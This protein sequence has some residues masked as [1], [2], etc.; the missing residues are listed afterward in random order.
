MSH[1][2]VCFVVLGSVFFIAAGEAWAAKLLVAND[3]VDSETCGKKGGACRSISQAIENASDGD[4]ITVGPGR[5]GDLT[6]D[7]M[8]TSPGEETGAPEGMI[9]VDKRLRIESSAGATATVIDARD[10]ADFGVTITASGVQFGA[11][12]KGFTV[13]GAAQTSVR[14]NG[15]PSDVTIA[16]NLAVGSGDLGTVAADAG[17]SFDGSGATLTG[18]VSIGNEFGFVVAGSNSLLRGNF[19]IGNLLAGFSMSGSGNTLDR[20][21]SAANGSAGVV[22]VVP[23]GG[24]DLKGNATIGNADNGTALTGDGFTVQDLS[25]LGNDGDGLSFNGAPEIRGGGVYGN[26]GCGTRN[27][28]GEAVTAAKVY[29]GSPTGPGVEEPADRACD[30]G[31]GSTTDPSPVVKKAPKLKVKPLF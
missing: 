28:S 12:K 2:R 17:F 9:V 25:T 27:T 16:G 22:A 10:V 20:N 14:T 13:I 31:A 3:G 29:W 11:P 4:T 26:I 15:A 30:V 19:A 21:T 1:W 23:S 7:G 8:F 18:N 24:G 6:N 5:Y